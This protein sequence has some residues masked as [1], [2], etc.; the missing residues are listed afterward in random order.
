M[1]TTVTSDIIGGANHY[2]SLTAW[3][4][5][6]QADITL[7]TGS[8]EIHEA[9]CFDGTLA[10]ICT[11]FGWTTSAT[12]YIRIFTEAAERHDG[13]VATGF[14]LTDSGTDT[15]IRIAEEFVR[16]EGLVIHDTG[17]HGCISDVGAS[18]TGE[19]RVDSC[20][21]KSDTGTS[22]SFCFSFG[23]TGASI[24]VVLRNNIAYDFRN[25]TSGGFGYGFLSSSCVAYLYNNLAYNCRRGFVIGSANQ[26]LINNIGD[27]CEVD[28]VF[29]A[30]PHA[31]SSNNFSSDTSISTFGTQSV[32]PTYVNEAGD[33]FHLDAADTVARGNGLDLSAAANFPFSADIDGDA[34]SAWDGGP[35]EV[36]SA[37]EAFDLSAE[38]FAVTAAFQDAG[39]DFVAGGTAYALDAEAFSM[40]AEIAGA[41]RD[42]EITAAALS[43]ASAFGDVTLGHH[44]GTGLYSMD[45]DGFDV[46]AA[47]GDAGLEF[48]PDPFPPVDYSVD[49]ESFLMNVAMQPATLIDSGEVVTDD[50]RNR[51]S[52][53]RFG[54]GGRSRRA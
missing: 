8:D 21:G 48:V 10:D 44:L 54:F 36:A 1:T 41:A 7:A 39:L 50:R 9:R 17:N 47:I 33:D 27:A 16:I 20:I 29:S 5:G 43:M 24:V 11:I 31:S 30:G 51:A 35:D 49:A 3:E 38:T 22:S 52:Q 15:A 13:T 40:E 19:I 42:V 2:P 14:R 32:S 25:A 6:E 18:G 28:Y 26:L 12:N 46:E 45:A 53:A 37:S 4:A 34:R 23:S